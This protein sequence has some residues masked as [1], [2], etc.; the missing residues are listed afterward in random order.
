MKKAASYILM[1]ACILTALSLAACMHS[2]QPPADGSDE[3]TQ[4]I[5]QT[6]PTA[7]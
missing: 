4:A 1:M 2:N 7:A 6:I 3:S 5:V